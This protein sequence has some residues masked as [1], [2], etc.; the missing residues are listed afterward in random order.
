MSIIFIKKPF[1]IVVA[2]LV[3]G[4]HVTYVTNSAKNISLYMEFITLLW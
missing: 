4:N 2:T 1:R 3:E